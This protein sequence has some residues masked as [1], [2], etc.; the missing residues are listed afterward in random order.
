MILGDNM[1]KYKKLIVILI[2]IIITILG[3]I[4]Y[5]NFHYSKKE[6]L[7]I[8]NRNDEKFDNIY[9]KTE[10]YNKVSD[11]KYINEIYAKD[12]IIYDYS[13][14]NYLEMGEIEEISTE[15]WNFETKKRITLIHKDKTMNTLEIKGKRIS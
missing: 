5:D 4:I 1:K 7:G 13:Y 14:I 9:I 3:L 11:E 8:I 15:I 10:I 2:M 12:N 6:I